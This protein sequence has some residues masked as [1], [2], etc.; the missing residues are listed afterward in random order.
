MTPPIPNTQRE[1]ILWHN[2]D[3]SLHTLG[4]TPVAYQALR[5]APGLSH[6]DI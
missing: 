1:A 4:S 5:K 3:E 2:I 6:G